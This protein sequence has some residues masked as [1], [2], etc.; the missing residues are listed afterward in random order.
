[1][2]NSYAKEIDIFVSS[3]YVIENV[4]RGSDPALP[5]HAGCFED[6]E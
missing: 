1:V 2:L 5:H 3:L 6:V 4:E